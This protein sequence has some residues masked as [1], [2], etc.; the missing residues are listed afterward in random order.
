MSIPKGTSSWFGRYEDPDKCR[1]IPQAGIRV[2]IDPANTGYSSCWDLCVAPKD[3]LMY[4]SPCDET[5]LGNQAKMVVYD[6]DA[7]KAWVALETERCT[8][9][10]L[11]QMPHTKLHESMN[12]IPDPEDPGNY[13]IVATTHSTDRAPHQPEWLP[14]AHV[15]HVWD[16][17]P[18][19][20]ILLYNPK[21]G[22]TENLGMPAP[23]ESI[24][25]ASYDAKHNAL[26]MIGF[27][28]G[29]VYRY[30]FDDKTV[31]DL[32]KAAEVFCYRLHT[33]PDGNIYGCTKSGFLWRVNVDT[34]KLEDLHW[35]MPSFPWNYATNTWY[36]YMCQAE[37]VSDHEFVFAGD[38]GEEFYLFDTD[39]C[40]VK[41][42]GQRKPFD[43]E[44]DFGCY[45]YD[46]NEFGVDKYGVLWYQVIPERYAFPEEDLHVA[47]RAGLLMSWDFRHEDKPRCHGV[48][49]T[50]E[51][52]F[53]H[54]CCMTVDAERDRLYMLGNIFDH[55]KIA[56]SEKK[57]LG[58]GIFAIDLAEFR[59]HIGEKGDIL[60]IAEAVRPMNE[61]EAA[62]AISKARSGA[63]WA[64]EEVS[65][66]NPVTA[67]PIDT[68]TPVRLWRET[69]TPEESAVQFL[70]W[71]DAG[72]LHGMCKGEREWYFK[73]APRPEAAF[74]SKEEAENDPDFWVWRSILRSKM[75][76]RESDGRYL[77]KV[78]QAFAFKVTELYAYDDLTVGKD[79]AL[80]A[81]A[82]PRPVTREQEK[83][84][85]SYKLP[86][87]AGRR[88][89][90]QASALVTLDDGTMVVG[91]RDGLLALL[92]DGNT[93]NLGNAAPQGP[94]RCL[95]VTPDGKTVYGT[96][97][98]DEDMGTIFTWDAV[99]GL[100]QKGIITYN[101]HGW[102]DGPTAAHVL[103][104][105]A[106]S[107]DGK[108]LAVGNAD[109]IGCVHIFKL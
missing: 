96:A 46:M 55:G 62:D 82:W 60:P 4:Y 92:K 5:G 84:I 41:T 77:V 103:T 18:G 97:G 70:S 87:V 106:V 54:F 109:R 7:D 69:E 93:F 45:T 14:F 19:S 27:M 66:A 90:A 59:K 50:G 13:L 35:R 86:E 51:Y 42:L 37:N 52:W 21:T 20:Y 79:K 100:R 3:G 105:I 76:T 23:R 67:Y 91:T 88:Y 68:V 17:Y 94:V 11:R 39:T 98:D 101:S 74:S 26:Y 63:S 33:G 102:M 12:A 6:Y 80:R 64:G 75:E 57:A 47:P 29:H 30:S 15:D 25:G 10:R 99:N 53:P 56:D 78:P 49:A 108:Y 31:K 71:D 40:K 107:P 36:R 83:A 85:A 48:V 28:R 43:F 2:R 104:S 22:Y 16:G 81:N 1:M 65:L 9:P 32:G 72:N 44:N 24:Y 95:C 38:E 89:L 8:L 34:E 58:F 61:K 73:I